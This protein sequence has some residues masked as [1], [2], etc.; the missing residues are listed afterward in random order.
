MTHIYQPMLLRKIV[1][2]IGIALG[3]I[4]GLYGSNELNTNALLKSISDAETAGRYWKIGAAGE[5]S[6]YQIKSDVWKKYSHVPFWRATQREYQEEAKRVAS[7]YIDEIVNRLERRG[8][9]VNARSVALRWNGGVNQTKFS[10]HTASY[11]SRV[12]NLYHHYSSVNRSVETVSTPQPERM[13]PIR[14]SI[15]P[16]QDVDVPVVFI[17]PAPSSSTPR[18][19]ISAE[20]VITVSLI[21]ML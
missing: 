18:I 2:V 19:I 21:A 10:R 17:Q 4:V 13:T 16:I 11:A 14:I 3:S 20:P 7:C 5:R 12:N 9:N 8:I 15:D 6:Q 1:I